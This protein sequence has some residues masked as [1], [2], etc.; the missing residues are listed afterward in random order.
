MII[1]LVRFYQENNVCNS[2]LTHRLR[3]AG[4]PPR[5][6]VSH[7]FSDDAR[8]PSWL[9]LKLPLR[10]HALLPCTLIFTEICGFVHES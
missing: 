2:K 10:A 3:E 5:S 9:K 4:G 6:A 7:F 1:S 8:E